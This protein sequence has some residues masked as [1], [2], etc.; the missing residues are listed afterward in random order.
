MPNM[1]NFAPMTANCFADSEGRMT[2]APLHNEA[3]YARAVEE[4]ERLWGAP[5]GTPEGDH[6]EI[7]ITL[8]AAYED[9]HHAIE[10]PD[11]ID[12]IMERMEVLGMSRSDLGAL[13]DAGSGRVS[14]ILNRR[15]HL[16][17]GMIRKLADGLSLSEH[18]LVQDYELVRE[19]A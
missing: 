17:V 16:T 1:T 2:M 15:R 6:L 18:C 7:L 14:E 4:I 9:E 11:P 12:A 3:D 13:I 10:S 5:D 8:V 19:C